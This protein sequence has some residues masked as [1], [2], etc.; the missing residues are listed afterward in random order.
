MSLSSTLFVE[1]NGCGI[2]T[3][4]NSLNRRMTVAEIDGFLARLKSVGWARRRSAPTTPHLDYCPDCATVRRA[5][6]PR[7]RKARAGA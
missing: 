3:W 4:H 1:C 6:K 2:V 7:L 5:R